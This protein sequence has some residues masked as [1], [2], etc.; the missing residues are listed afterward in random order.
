MA[1]EILLA[2]VVGWERDYVGPKLAG[3][4]FPVM[5]RGVGLTP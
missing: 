5:S 3:L 1:A 2:E 4:G